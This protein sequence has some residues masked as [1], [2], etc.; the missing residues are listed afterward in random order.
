MTNSKLKFSYKRYGVI[1]ILVSFFLCAC[2]ERIVPTREI[3]P[4]AP[5]YFSLRS[6][7]TAQTSTPKINASQVAPT[8]EYQLVMPIVTA[9]ERLDK[10]S[11]WSGQ[12]QLRGANIYQRRVYPELD[13]DEFM[14]DGDFG[15]P[16]TQDDFDHLA[17]LGANYVNI[18]HPGLFSETFPYELDVS[19][20]E[21]LDSLL[22]M[23]KAADLF[24][25]ITFRTGPGRSEFWAFY[26]EDTGNDPENGWFAPSYYNNRMWNDVDA[27]DA[28]VAMWRYTANRYKEDQNV[29]GYDLMCEPNSN[30][31][32]SLP[33]GEALDIWNPDEF[34]QLYEGTLYDWNQLYPRIVSAIRDVDLETPI[35][36]GGMSYSEMAWLPYMVQVDDAKVVYAVHQYD[37]F[38]FTHQEGA[39]VNTYP[40]EFDTDYDGN[41][42][43]FDRDWIDNLFGTVDDF[44]QLHHVPVGV[45]EYGSIR[46][47]PGA[48]EYLDDEMDLMEQRDLNYAIWDWEPSW[49][50]WASEVHDF[51]FRFGTNPNNLED[52]TDNALLDVIKSYW[53]RNSI[54]PSDF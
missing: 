20:Q 2:A 42:D 32:G 9:P 47:E 43:V 5:T 23:A 6:G 15:P 31:V 3:L 26:G 21:N 40:G 51:N 30:D 54:F 1:F 18:S 27:Q 7:S 22:A 14:G 37:P 25:V 24:V 53:Q 4:D 46:W 16:F 17:E 45:N 11:L 38:E 36:V 44:K 41:V 13:G 34:Y 28:W 8:A 33:D 10:W 29:V 52:T 48:S 12:T 35:V 49:E 50:P 39:L 19:A